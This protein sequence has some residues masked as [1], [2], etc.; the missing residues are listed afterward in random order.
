MISMSAS[1]PLLAQWFLGPSNLAE[2]ASGLRMK[3]FKVAGA[4]SVTKQKNEF[5]LLIRKGPIDNP[6]LL[7][8]QAALQKAQTGV[9]QAQMTG[10]QVPPEAQA[11][12]QQVQQTMKTMPPQIS[13]IPVAQDES[14]NHLVEANECFEFLN[15]MDG[16]KLKS[17]T[18]EQQAAYANVHLHWSE[19]LAM[20]KKI[21]AQNKPPDKPPSESISMDI[22]KMPAAVAAQAV[23]KLGMQADPSLFAQQADQTLQHAVAKKAIPEALKQPN[24]P[25]RPNA[26]P[27]PGA[28]PPRQLRR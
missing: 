5:E 15:S 17:G 24:N 26:Q 10:Q 20:L 23:A 7:N 19:H 13:T 18:P 27:S 14:E 6:Q 3:G 2:V 25:E 1:N 4:T 11:M 8:A 12:M 21:T 22:S 9:Q 16:Q 28:E